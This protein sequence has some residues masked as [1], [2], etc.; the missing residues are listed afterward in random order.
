MA[1]LQLVAG[2][3]GD[4]YVEWPLDAPEWTPE[5]RDYLLKSPLTLDDQGWFT[6]PQTP[7]LGVE[8][9]EVALERTLS[10]SASFH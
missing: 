5:R 4:T 7:G 9:D 3:A 6:L 1:N 2:T 10:E 8:L